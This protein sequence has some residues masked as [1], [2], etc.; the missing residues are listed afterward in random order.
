MSRLGR[1]RF[2][3]VGVLG[4]AV[5]S[6]YPGCHRKAPKLLQPSDLL[7]CTR[8]EVQYPGGALFQFFP[9]GGWQKTVLN[10]EE[11][12]LARSYD[13]RTVTDQE[14]IKALARFLSQDTHQ[15]RRGQGEEVDEVE[16]I[17]TGYRGR[18]CEGTLGIRHTSKATEWQIKSDASPDSLI[19][20]PP[21]L[22]SL[23]IR[24]NCSLN[25]VTLDNVLGGSL[26]RRFYPD[27]NHWCDIVAVRLRERVADNRKWYPD[28]YKSDH[29]TDRMSDDDTIAEAFICPSAQSS[30]RAENAHAECSRPVQPLKPQECGFPLMR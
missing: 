5:L 20:H 27:P 19:L 29:E 23:R 11:R 10:E 16:V 9:D 7:T 17:I 24:W 18:H 6:L 22:Q 8:L 12:A 28:K 21:E 14:Q 3:T 15:R 4:A 25:L 2:G 1:V 30:P 13:T 26:S